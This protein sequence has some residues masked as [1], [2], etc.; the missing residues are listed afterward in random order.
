MDF[1][2]DL[3]DATPDTIASVPSNNSV[4]IWHS[5]VSSMSPAPPGNDYCQNPFFPSIPLNPHRKSSPASPR[6][7]V[8][9]TDLAVPKVAI[10]RL[11]THTSCRARR[12]STR[13]CE[14]CRTRK[15][16]CDGVRP[17]CGQCACHNNRC[18]YEDVK[19]IRDKKMLD[20]LAW[21]INRYETLLRNMEG[22][23][24]PATM[25]RI[26]QALKVC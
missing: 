22:D 20:V 2:N 24:D 12:R 17:T 15:S 6:L 23:S 26:R 21:R 7:N 8:G 13:A 5:S 19:R 11:A 14:A 18:I 1:S 9:P 4:P 3:G 10:P 25:R 16:K